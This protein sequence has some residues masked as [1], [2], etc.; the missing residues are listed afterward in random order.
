MNDRATRER[1]YWNEAYRAEG[2]NHEKY[3]WSKSFANSSHSEDVFND[4][5]G[6]F[7][8]RKILTIGGGIDTVGMLLAKNNNRVVSAD[9]SDVAA[10]Q[11]NEAARQMG[12]EKNLCAVVMDCEEMVFDEKF[13]VV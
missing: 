4:L 9:I 10:R 1:N 13:D 12:I 6:K 8:G 3:L 7:S 11:T 2:L 5:L